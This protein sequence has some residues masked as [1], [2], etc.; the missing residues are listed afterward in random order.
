ML[1]LMKQAKGVGLAAPQ[2]GLNVRLFRVEGGAQGDMLMDTRGLAALGL[3]DLQMH[4]RGLNPGR[5]AGLL[6]NYG[7]Y[8][9]ENGDN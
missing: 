1:E 9:Y 4:F 5:V 7:R 3:P 6:F 8:I 2:V